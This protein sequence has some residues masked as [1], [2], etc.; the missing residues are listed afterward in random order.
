FVDRHGILPAGRW[1]QSSR[2]RPYPVRKVQCSY[3]QDHAGNLAAPASPHGAASCSPINRCSRLS[4]FSGRTITLKCVI[5][6]S[7]PIAIISTPLIFIPSISP[8]NST[9][10]PVLLRHSPTKQ[11]LAPPS[12]FTALD[13][14]LK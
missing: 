2:N 10:A 11:K 6:P 13:R 1:T 8:S 3:Y 5:L 9:T 7:S 4:A 14:Y 12:T